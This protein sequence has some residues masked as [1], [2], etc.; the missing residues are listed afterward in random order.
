MTFS[1]LEL[2]KT[3]VLNRVPSCSL[4]FF[5]APASELFCYFLIFDAGPAQLMRRG[6]LDLETERKS[7]AYAQRPNRGT[8]KQETS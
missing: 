8:T 2:D 1:P 4:L 7:R 6:A 3:L 5:L